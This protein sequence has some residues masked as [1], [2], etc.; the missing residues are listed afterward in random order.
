M[1]VCVG[2][3]RVGLN[4]GAPPSVS[5]S[6]SLDDDDGGALH[7][8]V[9]VISAQIGCNNQPQPT[10]GSKGERKEEREKKVKDAQQ[11]T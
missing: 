8:N 6:L 10:K 4:T 2:V 11:F 9:S 3:G 5:V 7:A 1:V